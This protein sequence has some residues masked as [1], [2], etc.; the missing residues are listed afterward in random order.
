MIAIDYTK[1][2]LFKL[3]AL[4]LGK[5]EV[6]VSNIVVSL[7]SKIGTV[8][9]ETEC[10]VVTHHAFGHRHIRTSMSVLDNE[11]NIDRITRAGLK[12]AILNKKY[13]HTDDMA[14]G[15]QYHAMRFAEQIN[16]NK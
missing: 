16:T 11:R 10:S 4:L 7:K 1:K 14:Y 2:N 12:T 9:L 8:L 3:T 6:E 13:H 15:R 5:R